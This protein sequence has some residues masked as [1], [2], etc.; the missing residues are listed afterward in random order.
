MLAQMHINCNALPY[1]SMA[2]LLNKLINIF[3]YVE[4][5]QPS[6]LIQ[7]QRVFLHMT[8]IQLKGL[9]QAKI[10]IGDFILAS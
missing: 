9:A 1:G 2:P 7:L 4:A 3:L 10:I 5:Q 6:W 8:T